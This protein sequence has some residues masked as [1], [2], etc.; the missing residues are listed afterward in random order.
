[1]NIVPLKRP[2]VVSM[3]CSRCGAITDAGCNCGEIYLPA[4]SRA[5]K[6]IQADHRKSDRAIAEQLGI[7]KDTVRRARTGA[8]APV[9]KR[10]GKDGKLRRIP[11]LK[12]TM[13]LIMPTAEEAEE[14]HQLFLLDTATSLVA[15]MSDMTRRTFL[16][17]MYR[18]YPEG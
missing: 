7:G 3:E 8:N 14:E 9:G 4:G 17:R 13:E 15:D 1:M 5:V 10:V 18:S 6:A 2:V 16:A 11:K 12:K